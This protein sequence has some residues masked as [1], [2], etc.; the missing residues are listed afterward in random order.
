VPITQQV[1]YKEIGV[2]PV[3][4]GS[5]P[6]GY[7]VQS[8]SVDP[9]VVTAI[10]EPRILGTVDAID[11]EPIDLT[12]VA[13]SFTRPVSLQVPGDIVL[14]RNDQ[15]LVSVQI[16]AL[17]MR[18]SIR[19]PVRVLNTAPTLFLASDVPIVEIVASGPTDQGLSAADVQATADA[20]GLDA[21]SYVLP[22][23]IVLPD[24]FQAEQLQP[25]SVPV[26]LREA[27]AVASTPA[28]SPATPASTPEPL[29]ISPS[30]LPSATPPPSASP[31]ATEGITGTPTAVPSRTTTAVPR[32]P[33]RTP[34]ARPTATER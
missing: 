3:V 31:T 23:R 30:P 22:V 21:G 5:V 33:T 7:W 29:E 26:V 14:A 9:A 10:A 19:V 25:A 34:T 11:T 32:T 20:A 16:A 18:Q 15:P 24:R 1:S 4:R 6:P 2:R 12:G 27:T 28:P 17:S 8:V 13:T